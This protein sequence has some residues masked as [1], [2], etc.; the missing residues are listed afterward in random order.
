MLKIIL[1]FFFMQQPDPLVT[2]RQIDDQL[3]KGSASASA[4]LSNPA[5]MR[6]HPLT[7]FRDVIRKHA[8][9]GPL[10][11][12]TD[13]EAGSRITIKGKIQSA[14]GPLRNTLI[15]VYQTDDR[16]NYGYDPK[17][18]DATRHSTLFAYFKTDDNGEFQLVTI[19]PA[20][21]PDTQ[22]AQH[23]HL[24][25]YAENGRQLL[26]TE[27]LFDDDPVLVGNVRT[28]MVNAGYIVSKN[29]GTKDKPV[30]SYVIQAR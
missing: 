14:T 22:V 12:V 11:M 25:A 5:Y 3:S 26:V 10:V 28:Q 27:L 23:I 29:S 17:Y 18:S 4:V 2:I 24:H 6:L 15:Y 7:E 21:Y 9:A 16:G 8:K 13:K 19:R 30:F 20:R 1:L